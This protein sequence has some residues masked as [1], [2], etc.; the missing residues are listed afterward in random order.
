MKKG[1][2]KTMNGYKTVSVANSES[3]KRMMQTI[4]ENAKKDVHGIACTKYGAL[5]ADGS[6]IVCDVL[7]S[8][9]GGLKRIKLP[10]GSIRLVTP[11]K[12]GWIPVIDI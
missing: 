8:F 3:V 11:E 10:D 12:E 5:R 4:N 7:E 2:N 9:P 1:E 6:I